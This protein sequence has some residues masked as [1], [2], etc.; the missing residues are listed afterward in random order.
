M[1]RSYLRTYKSASQLLFN[2]APGIMKHRYFWIVGDDGSVELPA[3]D[4]G[5]V[6]AA[7]FREAIESLKERSLMQRV[8]PEI[9]GGTYNGVGPGAFGRSERG[10]SCVSKRCW[11]KYPECAA[12]YEGEWDRYKTL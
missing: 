2:A 4:D 8:L 12:V 1:M 11:R 9:L 6:D 7:E 3:G 10:L 5:C